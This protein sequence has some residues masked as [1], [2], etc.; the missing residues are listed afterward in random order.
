MS[1]QFEGKN[2]PDSFWQGYQKH[3]SVPK[4]YSEFRDLFKL[5]YLLSWLPIT[6]DNEKDFIRKEQ[7]KTIEKFEKLLSGILKR[8]LG[9]MYLRDEI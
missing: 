2:V 1:V 8:V 6:Y 4:D 5:Y 3:K 9:I 7:L